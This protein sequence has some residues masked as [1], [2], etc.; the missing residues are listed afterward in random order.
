MIVTRLLMLN[1]C[2]VI[3]LGEEK[4]WNNVLASDFVTVLSI[5]PLSKNILAVSA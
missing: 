5:R 4:I 1:V 2:Y 3:K